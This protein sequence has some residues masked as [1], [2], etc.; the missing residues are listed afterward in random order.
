MP[1]YRELGDLGSLVVTVLAPLSTT[2]L[3]E[4]DSPA[5]ERYAME[6]VEISSGT[7]WEAS[8]LVIYGEV[9][10]ARG[11][12]EAADAAAA[13]ALSVALGAGLENWFRMAL[14]DLAGTTAARGALEDAAVLLGAARRN[15]P[16]YGFDPAVAA[17]SRSDAGTGSVPTVFERLA[18][19]GPDDDPR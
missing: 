2:V 4:G 3:K 18:D 5:A 14:R 10:A 17:R 1:L 19:Q 8:A 7:G 9:L 6:A 11:D 15:L 16:A 13:R 12:L